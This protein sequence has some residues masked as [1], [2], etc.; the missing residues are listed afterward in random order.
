MKPVWPSNRYIRSRV[1]VMRFLFLSLICIAV[2]LSA[3]N[4]PSRETAT[5]TQTS[6]PVPTLTLEALPAPT[7]FLPTAT[8]SEMKYCVVPGLLNVRSGPGIQYSIVAILGQDTCGTVAA[9]NDDLSWVYFNTSK[10]SGWVYTKYVSGQGDINTLPLY[11]VLTLTLQA[12]TQS[13]SASP[14]AHP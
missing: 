9:R 4:V 7:Q 14:T 2:L 3:C 6:I 12:A 11:T 10:Y 5:S 8:A 1:L 13:P